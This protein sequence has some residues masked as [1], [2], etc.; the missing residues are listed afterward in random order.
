MDDDE[1]GLEGN[2]Y[3]SLTE[4]FTRESSPFQ[5]QS[6]S[7][8][9]NAMED[10]TGDFQHMRTPYEEPQRPHEWKHRRSAPTGFTRHRKTKV[11]KESKLPTSPP[12]A[13]SSL[14]DEERLSRSLL[15]KAKE[16]RLSKTLSFSPVESN[17]EGRA[18]S[19]PYQP[20]SSHPNPVSKRQIQSRSSESQQNQIH[21]VL[22]NTHSRHQGLLHQDSHQEMILEN[23]PD[24]YS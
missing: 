18:T 13:G 21:A 16:T 5:R 17:F 2:G 11:S 7:L 12:V 15:R 20:G 8:T 9:R 24:I 6:Y 1:L 10:L 19:S 23:L 14:G 22:K 4:Q 3:L